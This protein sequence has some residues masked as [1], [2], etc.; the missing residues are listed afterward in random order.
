MI[1][2]SLDIEWR[3]T[4]SVLEA[5][6][7]EASLIKSHRPAANILEKDDK[8]FNYV[9]FTKEN[10]PRMTLFVEKILEHKC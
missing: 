6:I 9:V 8:S 10:F 1:E 4:D 7:L 5:L 2:D 3:E